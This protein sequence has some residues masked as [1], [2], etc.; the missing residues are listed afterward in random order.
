MAQAPFSQEAACA[1]AGVRLAEEF[2]TAERARGG[3]GLADYSAALTVDDHFA[4]PAQLAGSAPAGYSVQADSVAGAQAPFSQEAMY[5][6]AGVR[7]AEE[8]A[9]AERARD[10]SAPADYSA[11]LRVD[12]HS[13]AQWRFGV[14]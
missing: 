6:V 13:A 2:V 9:T 3:S 5:A 8:F 10:G 14:G 11:V 7:L 1:V 12:D 4:P